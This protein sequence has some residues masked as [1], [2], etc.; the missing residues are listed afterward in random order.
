MIFRFGEQLISME[1]ED[2]EADQV[3]AVFVTDSRHADEIL[4]KAGIL[5]ENEIQISKIGFCR[6][7]N[8]Q[9]CV[10]GTLCIPRL[11]DVLGSRYRMY[12]F[13]NR[14]NVVIVD[15]ENFSLRLIRRIQQKRTHQGET[16]E[17]FLYNFIA[18]FMSRDQEMLVAYERKLLNMEEEIT[19]DH[20]TNF[21]SKLMP[22][23]RELLNLRSYY[24]EMMDLSRELEENEN[25]FFLKKQL[26]Y[27]G[28]LTDR[29]DRLMSKTG[30]LL[31]YAQQVKEAYQAQIDARQNSNMQFLTVI[32]TI[33]FPLT[34]I[35]GWFG[36]NF[37]NMPGLKDGYP[38]VV[39]LSVVVI[40]GCIIIFKRKHII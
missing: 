21:Q 20:T 28:T 2:W 40:V 10:V 36:M 14:S 26:K 4:A 15:D 23:R 11:L 8:Q 30:H 39:A 35:T 24:D 7:E 3:P 22:I 9:D 18:E 34:L 29:A 5:Y 17:R 13:V 32:S 1:M 31:E 16:K 25:G 19:R 6:L 37:Q 12:F 33:F 27:F 38:W